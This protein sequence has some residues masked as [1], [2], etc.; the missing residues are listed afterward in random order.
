MSWNYALTTAEING[1][2]GNTRKIV[3][4]LLNSLRALCSQRRL[5]SPRILAGIAL[6][7]AASIPGQRKIAILFKDPILSEVAQNNPRLAFKHLARQ[8]LVHGL[9]VS[10]RT[11]CLAH[12]YERLRSILPASLLRQILLE[13]ITLAEFHEDRARFAITMCLSKKPFDAE[14]ELSLNLVMEDKILY[15]LGFS[16][17]PGWVAHSN[18]KEIFLIARIQGTQGVHRELSQTIKTLCDVGP[19]ALL[20]AALQGMADVFGVNTIACISSTKQISYQ[21]QYAACF[22]RSYDQFFNERGIPLNNAGLYVTSLP[23][24]EKSFVE[25]KRGHKIRTRKKRAFKHEIQ[26]MCMDF[27][28]RNGVPVSRRELS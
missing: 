23:L 28:A 22:R 14:G 16:I 13:G 20:I 19:A 9:P 5:H 1:T 10:V 7:A 24:E 25:I 21:E 8:Y 26:Q 17:V 4:I 12:H 2:E 18:A 27:F 11:D 3:R 6:R 15:I